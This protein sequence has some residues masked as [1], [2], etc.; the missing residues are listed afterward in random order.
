MKSQVGGFS[1]DKA[2]ELLNLLTRTVEQKVNAV[3]IYVYNVRETALT[4]F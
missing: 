1:R 4:T 3:R 2:S